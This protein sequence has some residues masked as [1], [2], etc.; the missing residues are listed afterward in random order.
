M[1]AGVELEG[2]EG[3]VDL[4]SLALMVVQAH[5]LAEELPMVEKA[6]ILQT[7]HCLPA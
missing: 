5:L 3:V 2:K 6:R 1:A 4:E 7:L